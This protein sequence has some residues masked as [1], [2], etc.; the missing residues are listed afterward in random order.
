[1]QCRNTADTYGQVSIL[2]HW[3]IAILVICMLIAGFVME[4]DFMEDSDLGQ[5]IKFYHVSTGFLIL[6]LMCLRL[7]WSLI[8]SLPD[9]AKGLSPLEA[10]TSKSVHWLLYALLI[11]MPISGYVMSASGGKEGEPLRILPFFK[12][13]M[14]PNL[15]GRNHDLHEFGETVHLVLAWIII[16]V[17]T[18]HIAAAIKH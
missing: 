15:I 14:V 1:M 11:I 6:A 2:L 18:L 13:E 5:T 10:K 7:A 8:G 12:P 9:A 4:M 16:V 3:L 17:V